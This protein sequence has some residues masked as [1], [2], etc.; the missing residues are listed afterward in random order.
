MDST[1]QDVSMG[2]LRQSLPA[3]PGPAHPRRWLGALLGLAVWSAWALT[4]LAASAA[5]SAWAQCAWGALAG[6]W[7]GLL[8]IL[9][10][11][12]AHGSLTPWRPINGVLARLFFLPAWQPASGWQQAHRRHHAH[13]NLKALDDGYP[14]LSPQDWRALSAWQ[15]W[16]LRSAT[17]LPGLFQFYL[18][19]WWRHVIWPAR[20]DAGRQWRFRLDS[21]CVMCGV[22]AQVMWV[23][24]GVRDGSAIAEGW[25]QVWAVVW[26]VVWS[27][28]LTVIWPFLVSLWWVSAITLQQ[29]RHPRIRWFD[30]ARQWSQFRSQVAGTVHL[31]WPGGCG[32]ALF[33]IF[34]HTAHHADP[35]LPFTLLRGT[36]RALQAQWPAV[37]VLVDDRQP[38]RL[39]H[40]RQVLRECQLYDYEA[41]RWLRFD[42]VALT[43]TARAQP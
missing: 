41:Q 32:L 1:P 24:W 36:Q 3:L 2:R 28:A 14:P 27:V 37:V 35:R 42:E 20:P 4:W 9:G 12:A 15:R 21:L 34:E 29:H 22:L 7:A 19:V 16:R 40:L 18:G 33:N 25:A 10:H 30:D 6:T 39:R 38:W 26:T 11:D 43:A 23:A 8:V 13:T 5:S 31:R 17:S